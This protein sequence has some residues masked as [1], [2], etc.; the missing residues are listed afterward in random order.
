MKF[1]IRL[2]CSLLPCVQAIAFLAA[3]AALQAQVA[4]SL[5]L[6]FHPEVDGQ[7]V[8]ATAVQP[9]GKILIGGVFTSINGEPRN[10][11]ARLHSDGTLESTNTF[12]PQIDSGYAVSAIIVQHDGRILLAGNFNSIEGQPSGNIARLYPDGLREKP[13]TFNPGSGADN[14]VGAMAL[15]VDGKIVI[16]GFFSRF[17]GQS[18]SAIA[19]LNSNGTL[20]SAAAFQVGTG[21][22]GVVPLVRSIAI[23]DNGSILVGGYFDTVNGQPRT[24]IARLLP[25]GAVEGI[26]TFDVRNGIPGNGVDSIALQPD[27]KILVGGSFLAVNNETRKG[28]ARLH[29]NGIVEGV[30]EF[31]IGDGVGDSGGDNNVYSIALQADGKIL[32]G[33]AFTSMSDQPRQGIARLQPDGTVESTNVFAVSPEAA[34]TGRN[35]FGLAQQADGK[36]LS[37]GFVT[38]INE[39]L[40]AKIDRLA[41]DASTQTFSVVGDQQ[42][43]WQRSGAAP[44]IQQVTL[45]L[46]SDAGVTWN[47]FSV[48]E[49]TSDGWQFNGASLV[50]G[51]LLRARGRVVGGN[52]NASS[53]LIEQIS[54]VEFVPD[55]AVE[56]PYERSLASGSTQSFGTTMVDA[57]TSLTFYIRNVGNAP[58]IDIEMTVDGPDF[59]MFTVTTE[60]VSYLDP[61]GAFAPV[62]VR[63]SPST[64]GEKTAILHIASNDADESPFDIIFVGRGQTAPI[65]GSVDSTFAPQFSG[66]Y[67]QATAVQP[68]GKIVVGG[69]FSSVNGEPRANLARLL[70]DGT[71]ESTNT[72]EPGDAA[73]SDVRCIAVQSDGKIL[74]GGSFGFTRLN[75]DGT[76]ESAET[77]NPVALDD[78]VIA[79]AVQPDG[80]I[81]LVGYFSRVN[82]EPRGNIARLNP[83]GTLESTAT[84]NPGSG[85]TGGIL[86]LAVQ[87]DGKIVI[88]GGFTSVDGQERNTVARLHPDGTLEST[89]TF[90]PGTGAIDDYGD[91]TVFCLALQPD[92]KILLGGYFTSI[93]GSPRNRIVRL[94]SDG[95][96]ES[97]NTFNAGAG[98]GDAVNSITLQADGKILLAGYFSTVDDLPRSGFARLLSDGAVESTDTFNPGTG[99][100]GLPNGVTLRADGKI[101]LV[102]ALVSINEQT[103]PLIAQLA[104]DAATQCLTIPNRT[105][106]QWLRG[107]TAPE[108][109]P[110]TFEV[111]TDDGANWAPA[112]VGTRIAGG[113]ESTGLNLPFKGTL[114]ARGR[115][116]GATFSGSSGLVEQNAPFNFTAR[117]IKESVFADLIA[118][119]AEVTNRVDARRLDIAIT[120][121][122]RLLA[123]NLWLDD[124]HLDSRRSSKVFREAA[125]T[126]WIFCD[127]V[128]S[129]RSQ[130]PDATLQ[131]FIARVFEAERLLASIAIDD[132]IAAGA[133]SKRIE[134]AQS[135]LAR[136]DTR[137]TDEGC[138]H[139]SHAY[140]LAWQSAVRATT[141][142]Q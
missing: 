126:L 21:I 32:L 111:S 120:R 133:S 112:G 131:G 18:R 81:L 42:A 55:I 71:L 33:G 50:T 56:L 132:A 43:R 27:G 14:I 26:S 136:G 129:S 114:R 78:Q 59:T 90:S 68:D 115:T 127:L 29:A 66:G 69:N 96:L 5:D 73:A 39:P 51:N 34:G 113:W 61:H 23:Q 36:I 35:V 28:I 45:E 37:G 99:A 38:E 110:V 94:H 88:A 64:I 7:Y 16:G 87:P 130:I 128:K 101:I 25:H 91:G 9:D 49:R 107:G 4:G 141:S 22:G 103:R 20:E 102:G 139:G 10:L 15:Q 98:A 108:V 24:N 60:P 142:T 47:L 31:R 109:E 124:N 122:T 121:L 95:R 19:R 75:P 41:N 13:N 134:Q 123:S 116:T 80:K 65:A 2:R 82:D 3:S 70:P 46:S 106:V 6:T 89:N 93:D 76:P 72:F 100:S 135:F 53:G 1:I 58:L 62:T 125:P 92:G 40:R 104:N 86:G 138:R 84:F 137:V 54:L 119:R 85:A 67:V 97:T 105:Q 44:E 140:R 117:G 77:F 63:F 79:I 12:N 118:L 17:N 11:I 52:A 30:D 57:E 83:D 74:L 48:G 8:L